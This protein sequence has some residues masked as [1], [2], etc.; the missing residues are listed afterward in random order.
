MTAVA[1][2]DHGRAAPDD[3]VALETLDGLVSPVGVVCAVHAMPTVRGLTELSAFVADTGRVNLRAVESE[4]VFGSGYRVGAPDRARLVAIAEAAERYAGGDFLAEPRVW[5]TSSQLSGRVIEPGRFPRCSAAEYA[6][7]RCPVGPPDPDSPIRWVSGTDLASGDPIWVPATMSCYWLR[8]MVA[9]E[10]FAPRIS[11]GYA[12]H[13]DPAEAVLNGIFEV[14]ERDAA[15]LLWQQMLPVPL[16]GP[17]VTSPLL[18]TL[19]D[20]ARRHFIRAYL[21]DATTDL[22]VPTVYCVLVAEHSTVLR[23]VVSAG[24]ARTLT[25]AAERALLETIVVRDVFR[26]GRFTPPASIDEVVAH[27]DGSWFMAAAQRADAFDFL[28]RDAARRPPVPRAG[29]PADARSALIALAEIFRRR[30]IP[31]AVVD[32]TPAELARVGLTGVSVSI[33]DLLPVSGS[34]FARFRAQPRLY[35]APAR[36]GFRAHGEKELNPWPQPF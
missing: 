17:E 10:R 18:D 26:T 3:L 32:R 12:V 2:V 13:L 25:E 22:G 29:L 5:A 1:A 23:T 24:V 28:L 9:A 8:D 30:D 35:E 19:T 27:G 16:V 15:S 11:T 36:M 4:A 7:P 33:P 21:F 34:P 20:W 14:I 31:V 6:H